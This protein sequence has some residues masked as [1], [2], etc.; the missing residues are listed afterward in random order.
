MSCKAQKVYLH[1]LYIDGN[2]PDCLSRICVKKDF[3]LPADRA[4][5]R[6]GLDRA[7]FVLNRHNRN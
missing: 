5:I 4:D 1:L 7:D 6:H 3:S 2:F